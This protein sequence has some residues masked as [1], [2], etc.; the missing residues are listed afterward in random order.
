MYMGTQIKLLHSNL[1]MREIIIKSI[2]PS[3]ES[4]LHL[5]LDDEVKKMDMNFWGSL[6]TTLQKIGERL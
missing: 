6:W 5:A 3:I 2:T 4:N 1:D